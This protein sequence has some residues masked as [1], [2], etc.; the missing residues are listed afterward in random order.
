MSPQLPWKE[1]FALYMG[2]R[3]FSHPNLTQ[4]QYVYFL[5]RVWWWEVDP[6]E[7]DWSLSSGEI[8]KE[9]P[10]LEGMSTRE[11]ISKQ[12]K[13]PVV[14]APP[15]E[16]STGGLLERMVSLEEEIRE[17]SRDL[18]TEE[19]ERKDVEYER[20]MALRR[21]SGLRA[22]YEEATAPPVI[23][24]DEVAED[25][26]E[27]LESVTRIGKTYRLPF[28]DL[29]FLH[30]HWGEV[31]EAMKERLKRIQ[32]GLPKSVLSDLFQERYTLWV[33][34]QTVGTWYPPVKWTSELESGL[35]D[36]FYATLS[37]QGVRITTP[38][39][40]RFRDELEGFKELPSEK[41]MMDA[42]EELGYAIAREIA[43]AE[44][45]RK[46][47]KPPK[48]PPRRVFRPPVDEEFRPF[49]IER[50]PKEEVEYEP[51]PSPLVPVER[52]SPAAVE[53]RRRAAEAEIKKWSA[54]GLSP[55]YISREL[56]VD[57]DTV[58]KVL[59]E[60]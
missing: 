20:D 32:Q 8:A 38:M 59:G 12:L 46:A 4:Q 44:K 39:R 19:K 48:K 37:K 36:R 28:I 21:L 49:V 15:E 2:P 1:F 10:M 11:Q 51:V 55:E 34:E 17:L 50:V 27:Y 57:L 41:E 52:I 30:D 3:A 47:I 25:Y 45:I 29:K 18:R 14:G 43:A 5:S 53:A 60:S 9:Y 42:A 33:Y 24:P 13:K 56:R 6:H 7:I 58:K 40:A 23:K 16:L 26:A 31:S 35:R 54:M 22:K